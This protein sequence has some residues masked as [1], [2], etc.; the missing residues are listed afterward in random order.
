MELSGVQPPEMIV[1]YD[2]EANGCAVN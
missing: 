2:V 1:T